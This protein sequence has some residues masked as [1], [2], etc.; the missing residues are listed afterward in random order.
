MAKKTVMDMMNLE[1]VPD[2]ASVVAGQFAGRAASTVV[3]RYAPK[4]EEK[5]GSSDL[6]NE[7]TIRLGVGLA[8]FYVA[9]QGVLAKNPLMVH[10]GI[11]MASDIAEIVTTSVLDAIDK[12]GDDTEAVG[13]GITYRPR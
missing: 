2:G 13:A 6:I 8:G 7:T 3:K 12:N 5:I 10:G 4:V 9:S 11:S 1:K